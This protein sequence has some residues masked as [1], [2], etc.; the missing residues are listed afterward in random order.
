MCLGRNVTVIRILCTQSQRKIN[1]AYYW[2]EGCC[3]DL[4]D[5]GVMYD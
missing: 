1:S 2:K 5:L 3:E 4:K